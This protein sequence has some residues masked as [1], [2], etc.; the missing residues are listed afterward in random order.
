MVRDVSSLSDLGYGLVDLDLDGTDELLIAN[1]GERQVIY[2]LY[3]L[4]DGQLVH[5]F[6]GWERNSYELRDNLTILNIGSNSAAS[7]DYR[8]YHLRKGRLMLESITQKRLPF[9]QPAR[10]WPK[11]A[12]GTAAS[13]RVIFIEDKL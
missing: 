1:D 5:V 9:P 11:A 13:S 8:F 2:D 3:S 10:A 7:T 4:V 6:S 12:V